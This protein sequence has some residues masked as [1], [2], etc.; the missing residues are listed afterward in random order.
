MARF[1]G[2]GPL[3]NDPRFPSPRTRADP[4]AATTA[5]GRS[6]N[7]LNAE[8][9]TALAPSLERNMGLTTLDLRWVARGGA[10]NEGRRHFGAGDG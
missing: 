8:A 7:Q 5:L 1:C 6:Q 10:A 9:A 4:A 3:D 2:A